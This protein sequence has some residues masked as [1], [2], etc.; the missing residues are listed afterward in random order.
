MPLKEPGWWYGSDESARRWSRLLAPISKAYGRIT[1]KRMQNARPYTSRLPVLCVGNFTAG[2]TGKTPL[3]LRLAQLLR[4]LDEAPAFLSRGY[5]GR[6]R[7][8]HL[9]D[10]ERDQFTTTGDEP[11]LLARSAPTVVARDRVA[12]AQAIE[13]LASSPTA[14]I[15]DDGLQ[16]PALAKTLRLALIDGRRGIGNGEVIPSGPLRAPLA[17]QLRL[18]D[19]VIVN[20]GPHGPTGK[21]P[22]AAFATAL[23]TLSDAG[24]SGPILKCWTQPQLDA[25]VRPKNPV[26]AYAGIANPDRFFD[27]LKA[28]DIEVVR[29]LPF[30]DHYA[31]TGGDAEYLL[32]LSDRLDASL[33]TTEKD[34]VR[35]ASWGDARRELGARSLALPIRT[36]FDAADQERLVEIVRTSLAFDEAF[37]VE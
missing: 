33:I 18:V 23:A 8:P 25:A 10:P 22:D 31:F 28:C 14:I 35:L 36:T 3:A 1:G 20:G 6:V 16:N 2:G 15:M 30:K 29:A 13:N 11:L 37:L 7:G 5:G 4:D 24:F 12:G 19:T 17:L 34:L 21:P 26:I 9:V 27:T 32:R